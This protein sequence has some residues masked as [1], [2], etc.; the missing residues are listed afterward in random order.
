MR[1][2][3]KTGVWVI[4]V[5]V[6]AFIK[7]QVLFE[8]AENVRPGSAYGHKIIKKKVRHT[9][10]ECPKIADFKEWAGVSCLNTLS[11]GGIV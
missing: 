1:S 9:W 6:V 4:Q 8:P 5:L 7:G 3:L 11:G 2:G 10:N